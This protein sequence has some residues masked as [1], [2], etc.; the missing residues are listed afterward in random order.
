MLM[1]AGCGISIQQGSMGRPYSGAAALLNAGR[2]YIGRPAG[3]AMGNMCEYKEVDAAIDC[4]VAIDMEETV[5]CR[6]SMTW[7]LEQAAV[8]GGVW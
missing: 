1:S 4:D 7:G 8:G 6:D 5:V 2:A 3:N